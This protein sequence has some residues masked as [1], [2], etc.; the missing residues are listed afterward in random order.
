MLLLFYSFQNVITFSFQDW[1]EMLG[2]KDC[3][4]LAEADSISYCVVNFAVILASLISFSYFFSLWVPHSAWFC[5]TLNL[6]WCWGFNAFFI[7]L[8]KML[9]ES[10]CRLS[11]DRKRLLLSSPLYC[12]SR[13]LCTCFV[14]THFA[15][16]HEEII[17]VLF[18]TKALLKRCFCIIVLFKICACL[19]HC[20]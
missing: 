13:N 16:E 12:I 17:F 2:G 15:Q 1:M 9:M 14:A 5:F 7:I 11:G 8:C 20:F 3:L 4:L 6:H 19:M 18:T 10:L